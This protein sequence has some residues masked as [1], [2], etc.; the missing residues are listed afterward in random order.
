MNH[1]HLQNLDGKKMKWEIDELYKQPD[2]LKMKLEKY[3]D[4]KYK[5][6]KQIFQWHYENCPE[7]NSYCKMYNITPKEINSYKDILKIP[8]IPSDVFR[9]SDKLILSVP[10]NEELRIFTTSSTTS[11]KPVKFAFD[12]RSWENVR[13]FTAINWRQVVQIEGEKSSL[14]FL[15]PSP[16]ES[17]TGLVGGMYGCFKA[18]GFADKDIHFSVEKNQFDPKRIVDIIG[19]SKKPRHIYGPPFAYMHFVKYLEENNMTIS[20]D[21]GSRV[22]TTGG[23]KGV[24]E[25][26]VTREEFN[27]RV[28]NA[29][30]VD[31]KD[32]R[33][34]Y[35]STDIGTCIASCEHHNIHIPPWFHVSIRDPENI[36]EEVAEGEQG[37]IVLMSAYIFSYPAFTMPADMGVVREEKCE[38]GRTSQMV[39]IKGR[40]TTG[41][42]RGCAVRLEQFME[43]ISKKVV[44]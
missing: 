40:A 27:K 30:C 13:K 18:T 34:G 29:F 19:N 11:K 16:K 37:L 4:W 8:P 33:D 26:K 44:G 9:E 28:S 5:V 41:G 20:L 23:W 32:V 22:I 10:E 42:Q 17:D 1:W 25:N 36:R 21:E 38:C 39:Q 7:Y 3:H 6:F 43:G 24:E 15:T 14:I 12:K 31:E 35:G 2:A